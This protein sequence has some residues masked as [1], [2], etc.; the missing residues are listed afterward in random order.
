MFSGSETLEVVTTEPTK[1]ILLLSYGDRGD[2][3]KRIQNY[4]ID[5]GMNLQEYGADG[6][7]GRETEE[8]VKKFQ[9]LYGLSEDGIVGPI[10]LAALKKA[11][12]NP[13]YSRPVRPYPGHYVMVGDRGKDVEAIQRAVNVKPDGI[14]G[15]ITRDAVKKYQARKGLVVDGIVGPITWNML[16]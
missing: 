1:S 7:F 10:T 13:V 3:V 6:I 4:L 16:F 15:P 12:T 5:V 2:E 8:A 14:F 9:R 11:R